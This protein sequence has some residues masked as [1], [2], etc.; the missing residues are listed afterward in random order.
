[1]R[2]I[3]IFPHCFCRRRRRRRGC[4]CSTICFGRLLSDRIQYTYGYI[5]H[6]HVCVCVYSLSYLLLAL[7]HIIPVGRVGYTTPLRAPCAHTIPVQCARIRHRQRRH[8]DDSIQPLW[9][10]R[11]SI[12]FVSHL[13]CAFGVCCLCC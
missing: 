9:P 8:A 10:F 6:T 11:I 7:I 5:I 13:V 4:C 1:M 2:P 12:G 3:P